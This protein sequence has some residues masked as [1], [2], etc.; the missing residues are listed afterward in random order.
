MDRMHTLCWDC[1]KACGECSWSR[2]LECSPVPGWT[3]I[4]TKLRLNTDVYIQSY[5]VIACPEF[6]RDGFGGGTK[7]TSMGGWAE[8]AVR[9]KAK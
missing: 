9:R 8:A 4:E 3:A 5:I 1:R 2:C 7:R 6:E